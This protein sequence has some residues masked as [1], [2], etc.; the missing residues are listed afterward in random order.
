M[1]NRDYTHL[2]IPAERF[3]VK[4]IESSRNL[5]AKACLRQLIRNDS[6]IA[7]LARQLP[8]GASGLDLVYE[9]R[10]HE[11]PVPIVFPLP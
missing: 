4:G 5:S 9:C 8:C 7:V 1:D 11:G 10:F 6:S 3:D 2:P